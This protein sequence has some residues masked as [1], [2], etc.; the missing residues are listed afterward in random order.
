MDLPTPQQS[1]GR[2]DIIPGFQSDPKPF[3]IP[4]TIRKKIIRG[5]VKH[6]PLT[7]LTNH[8]CVPGSDARINGQN[9][10]IDHNSGTLLTVEKPLNDIDEHKI[11]F[12]EW[13]QA[14][15]RFLELLQTY[16]PG[17]HPPWKSHYEMILTAPNRASDWDTWRDYDIHIRKLSLHTP[18]DPSSLQS[19]IWQHIETNTFKRQTLSIIHKNLGPLAH[20]RPYPAPNFRNHASSSNAPR[21]DALQ[22]PPQNRWKSPQR[23]FL[24]G[25][26]SHPSRQCSA[27]NQINGK[28]ILLQVGPDGR[29]RDQHGLT[30]C[31]SYNGTTGC[32]TIDCQKGRHCCS[33]CKSTTHGGQSCPSI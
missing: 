20:N 28:P 30:Y 24:C 25:D 27:T 9:F 14:W 15:P 23:C 4:D 3:L 16:L 6:I 33:L 32:T 26:P 1:R 13:Q 17:I 10:A 29:R 11:T 7:Y 2:P 19:R 12:D 21:G 8:F 18:V 5:W 22:N 31:F